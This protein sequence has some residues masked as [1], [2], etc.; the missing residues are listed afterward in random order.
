MSSYFGI[1]TFE[2]KVLKRLRKSELPAGGKRVSGVKMD[3]MLGFDLGQKVIYAMGADLRERGFIFT[4]C[5]RETGKSTHRRGAARGTSSVTSCVRSC[6]RVDKAKCLSGEHTLNLRASAVGSAAERLHGQRG[7]R[8]RDHGRR[9]QH[10]PRDH[11]AP[12][13]P[14]PV[15]CNCQPFNM[16]INHSCCHASTQQ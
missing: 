4:I 1:L 5:K 12:E 8:P 9:C 14:S 13:A 10:G 6:H 7:R 15:P 3:D 16:K 11:E 2:M